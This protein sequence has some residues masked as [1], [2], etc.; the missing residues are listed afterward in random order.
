HVTGVQTC[1]LPISFSRSVGPGGPPD[2]GVTPRDQRRLPGRSERRFNG[3]FGGINDGVDHLTGRVVDE[4][5][6]NLTDGFTDGFT[7][8]ALDC[9]TGDLTGEVLP[10]PLE[11]RSRVLS[12]AAES[13]SYAVHRRVLCELTGPDQ[14]VELARA[15]RHRFPLH[16]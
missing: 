10:R 4:F 1:A 13:D 5:T 11:P 16:R 15:I 6:G 3:Q 2:P 12:R 8:G 9:F 7:G 14:L